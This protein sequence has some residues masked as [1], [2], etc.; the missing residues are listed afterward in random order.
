MR[1]EGQNPRDAVS[2]SVRTRV[3][4]ILM[5]V[6]TTV[7]GMLPLVLMPGAGS[8]LYRGIGA[9]VV[10]GLTVSTVFTLFVVPALFSLMLSLASLFSRKETT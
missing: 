7:F 9:V 4:P 3:R 6:T 5:S 8:E 10:G 2:E 1:E